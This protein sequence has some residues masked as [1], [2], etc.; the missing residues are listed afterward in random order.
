VAAT[1]QTCLV[2]ADITGFTDYLAGVELDHAQD[3]V[4]DL[5]NTVVK[6]LRPPFKLA[7]L[8]GDAAFVHVPAGAIDGSIL[9]DTAENCYFSFRKR[10]LSIRQA[11]TCRCNACLLIPQL[12]L[13]L[14]AHQGMVGTQKMAGRSELVGADVI[15]A[16]RMLKNSIGEAAYLFMSDAVTAAMN[17]DPSQLGLRRH[18]E[19]YDHLGE[20]GGWVEDLEASYVD[21]QNRTRTYVADEDALFS[22]E[23]FLA[24]PPELVWEY[25]SSPAHRPQWGDGMTSIIELD[26]SGRRRAGSVNHCVHGDQVILQEFVDWRPPHYYTARTTVAPGIV[27]V[28]THE[29]EPVEGGAIFHDRFGRPKD[30]KTRD[31]L[32]QMEGHFREAQVLEVAKLRELLA[33]EISRR[34]QEEEPEVPE[35][36]EGARLETAVS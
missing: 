13:K 6:A 25:V 31:Q 23:N 18:V 7:K 16:H 30:R 27:L 20:I 26:P 11:S 36:N 3:I 14:V 24:A 34:S 29:V 10:L 5:I 33:A 4:A 19:N 22:F 9:L 2:I 21:Y 32:A 12:N 17:L 8:E 35:P 15:V 1:E 28:S